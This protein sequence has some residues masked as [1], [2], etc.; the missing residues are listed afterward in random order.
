[1]TV[2]VACE[3]LTPNVALAADFVAATPSTDL[4]EGQDAVPT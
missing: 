3:V 1:M 4:V 2:F